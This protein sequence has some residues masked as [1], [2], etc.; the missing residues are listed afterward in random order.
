MGDSSYLS[1][2]DLGALG[3]FLLAWVLHTLA[4]D[5]KLVSRMSLTTAMN[6]Q[7]EAWMRTM[8]EREIRIV[9][10]AIM[11]GLQQG[12]AFFASSSL[13]ALGGCFALLGASDRVIE[14]LS[15]LPLGGVPDRAAF[16]IKVLGLVLILAF[17]FFK[18]GWAYR[19]FNYCSIL[20]GAVPIPHGE[21]SRNPVTQ[22][23]VWR[24]TQMN[25]LAG[26]H[27]N[28]GLRG[29][30]FSIGYLGWFV[31][32]LVFVLSTLLLLAVLVR[33]QFFSAA[34]RAVIGQPPG[35][36]NG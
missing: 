21:A 25:M 14:V 3:F 7:R 8:A 16:Q 1:A 22:T 26:K 19:L 11:S 23:A 15:D 18:F 13:I 29:V 20:I 32:P 31:D 34:R 10:T 12:T 5:G 9:D 28:S 30:F 24:A 33:R 4:S 27:F 35:A 17:S 36:G 2:A 6:A